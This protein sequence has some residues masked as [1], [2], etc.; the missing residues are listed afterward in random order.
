[1]NYNIHASSV[2]ITLGVTSALAC[3]SAVRA[4]L[5][6]VKIPI[7]DIIFGSANIDYTL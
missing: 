1:M 3:L 7:R 4:V 6:A 5:R 2:L